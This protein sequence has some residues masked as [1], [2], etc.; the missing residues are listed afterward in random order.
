MTEVLQVNT[1]PTN[2]ARLSCPI[3]EKLNGYWH[4]NFKLLFEAKGTVAKRKRCRRC[5]VRLVYR[6][7][8]NEESKKIVVLCHMDDKAKR[9]VAKHFN[10]DVDE[11]EEAIKS[12]NEG[13]EDVVQPHEA[14]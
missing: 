2:F 4:I 5:K 6:A 8:F 14:A 10:I 7:S 9:D 1:T 12:V 11:V 13:G 3:C